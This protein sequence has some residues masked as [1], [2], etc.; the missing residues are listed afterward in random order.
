[1]EDLCLFSLECNT[2]WKDLLPKVII[3]IL[4][5]VLHI[6]GEWDFFWTVRFRFT[7]SGSLLDFTGLECKKEMKTLWHYHAKIF[8]MV[9]LQKFHNIFARQFIEDDSTALVTANGVWQIKFNMKPAMQR[10]VYFQPR[11]TTQGVRLGGLTPHHFFAW[12][13][14]DF[15]FLL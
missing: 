7:F 2:L 1:M 3:C 14:H 4:L 12:L 9:R 8:E 5:I 15:C 6:S 13:N 11:E 10:K